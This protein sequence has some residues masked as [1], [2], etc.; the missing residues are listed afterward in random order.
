MKTHLND[1]RP[2]KFANSLKP[3]SEEGWEDWVCP[4][5]FKQCKMSI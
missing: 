5:R 2:N 1:E 4:I 3:F